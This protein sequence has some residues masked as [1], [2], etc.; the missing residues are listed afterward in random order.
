MAKYVEKVKQGD[1]IDYNGKKKIVLDVHP[2]LIR[3]EDMDTHLTSC[4]CVGDLVIAGLE[5][6][7]PSTTFNPFKREKFDIKRIDK[8]GIY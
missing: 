4:A 8:G 3:M 7:S 2:F 1:V 5:T 6:P